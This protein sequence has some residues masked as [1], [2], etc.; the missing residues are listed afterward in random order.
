MVNNDSGSVFGRVA[1]LQVRF[2]G[3]KLPFTPEMISTTGANTPGE[4]NILVIDRPDDDDI[5]TD[6][7]DLS[8]PEKTPPP[9]SSAD[10][11]TPVAPKKEK[12]EKKDKKKKKKDKKKKK[13]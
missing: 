6:Y 7:N 3:S 4:V 9:P 11:Q 13:K 2:D 5:P 10:D 1:P 8:D 12:K